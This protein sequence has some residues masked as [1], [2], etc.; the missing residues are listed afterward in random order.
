[1]AEYCSRPISVMGAVRRPL[2]FQALGPVTLL[3]ALARAEGLSPEAGAEIIVTRS[4]SDNTTPASGL[5]Q[6]IPV[7]GLLSG[8]A[9]ELNVLLKG[10]EEIRVA[11]AG[12]LFVVGNVKKPG[13]FAVREDAE[14]SVLK[15]LALAEGLQPYTGKIAYIYR[16]DEAGSKHEIPVELARIM[17]R[18]SPDIPLGAD[19]VLYVPD[20]SG[21]RAGMAALEKALAFAT[22]A[23]IALIYT[24]R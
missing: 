16:R 17:S 7:K 15:A 12:K 6:R 8:T 19:D 4:H 1:V 3:E 11:E 14:P 23:S 24:G 10:G 20:A 21:R 5:L 2:T 18:K 13:A 22:G 9:P